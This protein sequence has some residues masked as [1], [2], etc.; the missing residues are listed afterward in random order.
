MARTP[1][2]SLILIVDDDINARQLLR[3]VME[4]E[5]YRVQTAVDGLDAMDKVAQEKPDLVLL[6]MQMPGLSGTEVCARLKGN[7]A[8]R[9][10]PVIMHTGS[11]DT[12]S[13]IRAHEFDADDYLM[14][15]SSMPELRSRVRSLLRLK[16]Y[17]D[18]LEDAASVL[19]MVARIS[20]KRDLFTHEHC[21]KVGALCERLGEHMGLSEDMVHRLCLGASLHDIGKI[22]IED[23]ILQKTGPLTGPERAKMMTHAS[24]G[25]DLVKPMRSLAAIVPLVR[26]HHE[27]LDGTGYPDGLKGAEI[28]LEVRVLAVAD[29]F[30]ALVSTRSY[31]AAFSPEMA[32]EIL[33]AESAKGWWDNVVV[34]ALAALVASGKLKEPLVPAA[35]GVV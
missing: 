2:S 25:S 22:V 16:Y 1:R 11:A 6:D 27:K 33:R 14:K 26:S 7:P 5:D 30:Q 9:L 12:I 31:K 17:T 10:I 34:E 4:R 19:A 29:I 3:L 20:E 18:D 15:G 13:K 23:T 32:V 21:K 24:M 8:T 35:P 28:S